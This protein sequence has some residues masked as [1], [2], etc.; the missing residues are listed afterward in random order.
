MFHYFRH[1]CGMPLSTSLSRELGL[2]SNRYEGMHK[3]HILLWP[4]IAATCTIPF[5]LRALGGV[6][7]YIR[8]DHQVVLGN[9]VMTGEINLRRGVGTFDDKD[10]AERGYLRLC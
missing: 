3:R 8:V 2:H 4:I 1:T 7:Y 9:T 5:R 6:V 10:A